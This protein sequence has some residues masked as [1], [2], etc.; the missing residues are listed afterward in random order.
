MG[1]K[2]RI[3]S[4]NTPRPPSPKAP[5]KQRQVWVA[6]I[7]GDVSGHYVDHCVAVP[8]QTGQPASIER[9]EIHHQFAVSITVIR[10]TRSAALE[11]AKLLWVHEQRR[12]I[13]ALEAQRQRQN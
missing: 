13:E 4:P 12:M 5:K 9:I 8:P 11:R 7:V 3:V 6:S 1:Y 10:R 2:I